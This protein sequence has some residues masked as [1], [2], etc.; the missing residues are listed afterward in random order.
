MQD[1]ADFSKGNVSLAVFNGADAVYIQTVGDI[2]N[3]PHVPEMGMT[4]PLADSATAGHY[5]PSSRKTIAR[6]NIWKLKAPIPARLSV[7]GIE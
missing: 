3:F 6:Q 4:V 7:A 1:F 5:Y 2:T